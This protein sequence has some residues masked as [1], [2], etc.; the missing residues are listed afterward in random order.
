[1]HQR[2][3]AGDYYPPLNT[4]LAADFGMAFDIATDSAVI[5]AQPHNLDDSP[6]SGVPG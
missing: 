5:E 3:V 1:M 4:I 6:G 2:L